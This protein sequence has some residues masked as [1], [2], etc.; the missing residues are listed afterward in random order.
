MAM[1]KRILAIVGSYRRNG[2][3]DLAVQEILAAC[4]DDGADVETVNLI[5][6]KIEF[7][8]NCRSCMQTKGPV[9]GQCIQND[10]MKDILASMDA[11]DALVL[12]APVN[13]FNVTAVTRRFMERLVCYGYWPWGK[14][15]PA[16]RI[17][18]PNKK[19]VL[20]TSCA[21][22]ALLARVATG[23][24]RALAATAKITGA[25]PVGKLYI[26]LAATQQKGELSAGNRKKAIALGH[27]LM[28]RL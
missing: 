24:M 2:V 11:A 18:K 6:R 8:T 13:F 7:C 4:R 28:S 23:A 10:G 16:N 26:G 5:D 21:M 3:I 15:A 25:K 19:A 20:V 14:L 12:A 27:K 17:V 1:G 22:P 9:R